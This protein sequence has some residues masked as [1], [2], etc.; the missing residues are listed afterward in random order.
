MNNLKKW[1]IQLAILAVAAQGIYAAVVITARDVVVGNGYNVLAP[2]IG[3]HLLT[4][5]QP[6]R[7]P[8]LAASDTLKAYSEGGTS[9]TGW[10]WVECL[11]GDG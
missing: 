4:G 7:Y 8:F 5:H 1:Y 6:T 3:Q 11:N 10:A 9:D 2:S